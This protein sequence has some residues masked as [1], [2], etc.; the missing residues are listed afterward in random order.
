MRRARL[1][2]GFTLLVLAAAIGSAASGDS[3]GMAVTGAPALTVVPPVPLDDPFPIRRVNVADDQLDAALRAAD[4][5]PVM[6]M[7]PAA[8]EARVQRAA[9]ALA[10]ESER[11]KLVDV[12]YFAILD[13][14]DLAGE[15]EWTFQ[16]RRSSPAAFSLESPNIAIAG[17]TWDDG[18]PAALG[19]AENGG[20][21]VRVPPGRRILKLKW[22]A[23]G[24][25]SDSAR[26]FDL[27][28]P[29]CPTA[30]LD[31]D[32]PPDRTPSTTAGALLTGPFPSARDPKLKRWT[33]RSGD[34]AR[35]NLTIRVPAD[36]SEPVVVNAATAKYDLADLQLGCTFE[37]EL[38]TARGVLAEWA[39]QVPPGLVVT[40]ALANDRA[41]WRF[42]S[43]TRIL[44]VRI[45]QAN[46]GGKFVIAAL[47]SL[48]AGLAP[49]P[50]LRPM[51]A[52]G[53][54]GRT[55]V[56]IPPIAALKR[57]EPGDHRIVDAFSS[58][59]GTR[60]II[61][62]GTLSKD[63]TRRPPSIQV[64]AAASEFRTDE[65]LDWRIDA[66]RVRLAARV[67]L[68]VMRGPLFRLGFRVP[69][70]FALDRVTSE[71]DDAVASAAGTEVEFAKPLSTGQR[72]TLQFEFLGP[73]LS[74]ADTQLPLPA[75]APLGATER[76][77]RVRF[78]PGASWNLTLLP[79]PGT[80]VQAGTTYEYRGIEPSG[81]VALSRI[82]PTFDAD[83][84]SGRI[85][86]TPMT[87][88]LSAIRVLESGPP[89]NRTWSLAGSSN[90]IAGISVFSTASLP[91]LPAVSPLAPLLAAARANGTIWTITLSRPTA[92]P[93]ILESSPTLR[94]L[95]VLGARTTRR[96]QGSDASAAA[97]SGA[98]DWSFEQVRLITTA[99]LDRPSVVLSGTILARG[100]PVLRIA[101]PHGAEVLGASVG[102][103]WLEPGRCRTDAT[104]A[105][106]VPLPPGSEPL[107]FEIEYR[108]AKS[109]DPLRVESRQPAIPGEPR[110]ERW[111]AVPRGLSA[112]WPFGLAS[113]SR[114]APGLRTDAVAIRSETPIIFLV[115][116]ARLEAAG[117][118]I[119]ALLA[120]IGWF[121]ARHA[122][123]KIG[124][125]L[126]AL[127]AVVGTAAWLGPA[128]WGQSLLPPLIATVIGAAAI[129]AARGVKRFPLAAAFVFVPTLALT[130]QAPAERDVVFLAGKPGSE[131]AV[132]PVALLD[133]LDKLAATD[134]P[135]P[136]LTAASYTGQL[137]ESGS[138]RF[139]ARYTVHSFRERES[140]FE[141]KLSGVR[142]ERA[143][144]NGQPAQPLAAKVDGYAIPL[145]GKGVHQ[146]E[147]AFAADVAATGPEREVRFS[148]PPASDS[149]L[150]FTAPATARQFQAVGRT[151]AGNAAREKDATR[152][153]A[154]LGA[155]PA[156][157]LRWRE[158]PAGAAAA[159][160]VREGCVWDVSEAAHR[161][162]ACYQLQV[163][164]GS[165][166]S[167]RFDLPAS[168]EPTRIAVR[169]LDSLL[170]P[171]VIRD[172]SIGKDANGWRPLT[173]DLLAPADGRLLVTLECEPRT[174]PSGTPVLGFP[175]TV[176]MTRE[177]A[178]Y[179]LRANG[180]AVE[181]IGRAGV[182]DFAADALFRDFGTVPDLRLTP[183]SSVVAFSPR[184]GETPELRPVLRSAG[185]LPIVNQDVTWNVESDR[186]TGRGT[187]TWSGG[188]AVPMIE[189]QTASSLVELRGNEVAAWS[190]TD[191]RVQVW[192][193][194]PVK[195]GS[196]EWIATAIAAATF[197]PPLP[198][199]MNARNAI[200]TLRL[201]FAAG[202]GVRV[203]NDK[204]WRT[205]ADGGR[206]R[207][208]QT[209]APLPPPRVQLVLP[210]AAAAR[211]FGLV[212]FNG[213]AVAYRAALEIPIPA[214]QPQHLVLQLGSVSPGAAPAVDVPPG[215]VVR[216]RKEPDGS[217]TWSLDVPASAATRFRATVTMPLPAKGTVTL[218]PIDLRPGNRPMN[219]DGAVRAFGLANA[220]SEV[221]LEGAT[222]ANDP[223]VATLRA[224]WPGEAERLRRAGGAMRVSNGGR[225]SLVFPAPATPAPPV[226]KPTASTTVAEPPASMSRLNWRVASAWIITV[227]GVLLLFVRAPRTTWP[228]QLG[229]LGGLL[230]YAVAGQPAWGFAAYAAARTVWLVRVV[231]SVR[232]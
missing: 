203:E 124:I 60:T 55:E 30:S 152:L 205:T 80:A 155:I 12:G 220:P 140:T 42:D 71:P 137:D 33:V 37:F 173:I 208:F 15:A 198:L 94:D 162:T 184:A 109:F 4:L 75:F 175:R 92:E 180:A 53:A 79:S 148:I 194:K 207:I 154:A 23:A 61:L 120:I 112:V 206:E 114:D 96:E 2:S 144:V 231:I 159:V 107:A 149:Q 199:A 223:D 166:P 32:L 3:G 76:D 85:R 69:A 158:G 176:G 222:L 129:A 119:A 99:T 17:L 215:T 195:D 10:A 9:R 14:G 145:A 160:S 64:T 132:V 125:V 51:N 110:V 135:G 225:V 89:A 228:E 143:T 62:N 133:R 167:F 126:L 83:I 84:E 201:R 161:L 218:P 192:L 217:L 40:D 50:V 6:Q 163:K 46:S 164:S 224:A 36:T 232:L 171:T 105:L 44:R 22:S 34:S 214:N 121:G 38:R 150:V 72:V 67:E 29:A 193:K 54:A 82:A 31:L 57:L 172:W 196:L 115:P 188:D 97:T 98:R 165:V 68:T 7:A 52:T 11:P 106:D 24:S 187:M 156:L 204:G 93:V 127:V 134:E 230:G 138:V 157:H 227:I 39:F 118:A 136:L 63:A 186:A 108:L 122:N 65:T 168:L 229:L 117:F 74:T 153:T 13:G 226:S 183:A 210:S 48:P 191:G 146:V 25:G 185:L 219:P 26:Q 139:T 41:D 189:F 216:E 45:R 212:E 66:R 86:I 200:Q 169:S 213:T 123:R 116:T 70:E 19:V 101:L 182:I 27:R 56:R 179:G 90:A 91:P 47:G 130:A 174:A 28:F 88:Q 111:W 142:L 78:A 147:V 87:G 128:S 58:G 20:L 209:D 178:V 77:G 95:V 211:G 197:D 221:Q 181:S 18:S 131:V 5:G 59:D 190:Q 49:L 113:D 104:N 73:V 21:T 102:S 141:A 81:V 16:N 170:V 35:L 8:F 1:A 43:A 202:R 100:G 103:N 151:G 177:S